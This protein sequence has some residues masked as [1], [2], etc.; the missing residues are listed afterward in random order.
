MVF[1]ITSMLL[2][3]LFISV[4]ADER[5]S[6]PDISSVTADGNRFT[7]TIDEHDNADLYHVVLIP[8]FSTP[9]GTYFDAARNS[10]QGPAYSTQDNEIVITAQGYSGRFFVA[11][12]VSKAVGE[13]KPALFSH[14]TVYTEDGAPYPLST[15]HSDSPERLTQRARR[16]CEQNS[17][18]VAI[19]L[20]FS[21]K[22]GNASSH[23]L[24]IRAG[25]TSVIDLDL[26]SVREKTIREA[27]D[28]GHDNNKLYL[29]QQ[30][31]D[32]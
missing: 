29:K 27:I 28:E 8:D 22:R 13:N 2:L 14:W 18:L 3:S 17:E 10:E 11:A 26:G 4:V 31:G 32:F 15:S 21:L 5:P 24:T 12:A 1:R 16:V 23:N 25:N 20:S 6:A 30:Q 19:D 7:I 9:I